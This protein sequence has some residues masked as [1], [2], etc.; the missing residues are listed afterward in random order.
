MLFV[1]ADAE[2][3]A[4]GRITVAYRRWASPRVVEGR[5]Y[6]TTGGRIR[7]DSVRAVDPARISAKDARAAG[8][9]DPEDL[10]RQLR[11]DAGWPTYRVSFRLEAG[12]DPREELAA[13]ADLTGEQLAELDRRLARYD[14][15]PHGPWTI[16]YLRLIEARPGV[17]AGDLAD[18][19]GRDKPS[20]KLDVRKLRNLG[21]TYSLPLG[22]RLSPR[23]EAY[24]RARGGTRTLTPEGTGT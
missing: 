9:T 24:L 17:R 21:L 3:V 20:F 10:R 5:V 14:A 4:S 6:R 13:D 12:P 2:G 7:V 11:G 23:G 19:A 8:R 1:A 22:Y 16:E 18:E 15:G